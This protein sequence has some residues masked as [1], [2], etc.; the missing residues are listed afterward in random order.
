MM[1]HMKEELMVCAV[2]AASMGQPMADR[3]AISLSLCLPPHKLST[4]LVHGL[5]SEHQ[6]VAYA[7]AAA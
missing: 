6:Y 3:A 4:E 2:H 7:E 5:L 1:L